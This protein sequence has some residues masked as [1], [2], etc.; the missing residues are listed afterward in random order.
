MSRA[1]D[2]A[3]INTG[4]GV[5]GQDKRLGGSWG[6]TAIDQLTCQD[7]W[8]GD[9][10]L[11]RIVTLP[12][13]EM[14]REGW[15]VKIEGKKDL[16][17]DIEDAFKDLRRDPGGAWAEDK[18]FTG[19]TW[20]RGYGGC[21]MLLGADDGARTIGDLAKPL[22][23]DRIRSFDW[24][25]P[26]SPRELVPVEWYADPLQPRFGEVSKYRLTPLERPPGYSPDLAWLPIV[27]ESRI[28]RFDG[29]VVS[30]GQ[31][32]HN[33]QPG[34]GDSIFTRIQ[35]VVA[36]F[37]GA[38]SGAAILLSD[39]GN[40]VL[41]MKGLSDLLASQDPTNVSV[42]ARA[43]A[44]EQA[45]S[46]ANLVIIDA[47]EEYERKFPSLAG[48]PDLLSQFTNR[49]ASAAR[50][51]VSLMMGQAPAGL[52]ATGDSDIRWFY[53]QIAAMQERK[54]RWPLQRIYKLIMLAK[55]GP[56]GGKEPSSWEVVF[57]P[58]WQMTEL[59]QS[60]IKLNDA[61]RAQI[62]I[63]TQVVTPE[64]VAQSFYGGDEYS[65][66]IQIDTKLRDEL[67]E[68]AEHQAAR[69]GA[70]PE[71]VFEPIPAD[72][73]VGPGQKAPPKSPK[74]GDKTM[75][76]RAQVLRTQAPI[77]AGAP[78]QPA[79]GGKPAGKAGGAKPTGKKT[80]DGPVDEAR[81]ETGKWT[82]GGGGGKGA[83]GKS[84]GG[85]VAKGGATIDPKTGKEIEKGQ[86]SASGKD[87]VAVSVE[88]DAQ[89]KIAVE[90]FQKNPLEHA[91][92]YLDAHAD[93]FKE[94][95]NHLGMWVENGE[96]YMDVTRVVEGEEEAARLGREHDQLAAWNLTQGHEVRISQT[97]GPDKKGGGSG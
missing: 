10:M 35:Q 90:D 50:M 24:M 53:D 31:M 52:K 21:G 15:Q 47:D 37:Q 8:R 77:Q 9:D 84:V 3:N 29:E 4:F 40:A 11:D 39:L 66:D 28:V 69:L 13:T 18:I 49:L 45:R 43:Q 36:D 33:V 71:Q 64:E 78:T 26:F 97:Q 58:L 96:V 72:P 16:A 91:S 6:Y 62:L 1:D 42:Q 73:A 14:I 23:E 12:A 93:K 81:D 87:L 51:P 30:R 32:L 44:I 82:V 34:W 2:W 80:D 92:G 48:Y 79:A 86:K 61:N 57:N 76:E 59:E 56:C 20:A 25:T 46:I 54:L 19:A 7:M 55:N 65:G 5:M 94:A 22:N 70:R 75:A 38:W 89:A 74:A 41:K 60:Q 67:Q 85:A 17:E 27:H 88:R 83:L 68:I 95:G 63:T